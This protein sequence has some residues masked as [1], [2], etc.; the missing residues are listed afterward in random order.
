M[1][2]KVNIRKPKVV[3]AIGLSIVLALLIWVGAAQAITWG[4]PDTENIYDNVGSILGVE[5][6]GWGTFQMCSGTLVGTTDGVD[7]VS[8]FLTAGH[9]TYLFQN[10]ID[11]GIATL[12]DLKVSF[13]N[14]DIFDDSTWVG[15]T[16][17]HTH[18]G[19]LKVVGPYIALGPDIGILIL[20]DFVDD[21]IEPVTL[22]RPFFLD[23]LKAKG[24]LARGRNKATFTVAGYGTML[25]WPPPVEIESDGQRWF[26]TSEY[27]GLTQ[28]WLNMSQNHAAGNG[29]TGY[30]D[31]GGP[32]FWTKPNGDLIQVGITCWGDIPT[33]AKS[34]EYRLDLP[35]VLDFIDSFID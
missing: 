35:E 33:V 5:I 8:V 1:K 21:G 26:S 15:V 18:P 25:A 29:G 2:G 32:A 22:P 24:N 23:D 20:E 30:G 17:I 14:E 34:V 28:R 19:L 13:D 12:D 9:C 4:Q 16:A 10:A 6:P 27:R 31:S 7:P 11:A 3:T